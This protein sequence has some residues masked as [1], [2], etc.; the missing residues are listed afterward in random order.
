MD[1]NELLSLKHTL[2]FDENGKFRILLMSDLHAGKNFNPQLTQA[3]E[4]TV[5]HTKP[6]LV[7]INGDTS[8]CRDDVHCE[9]CEELRNL[10]KEITRPMESRKIP[11]AHTFGNHDDNYGLPIDIQQKVYEEFEY[12]IS[13]SGDEDISGTGNYVLP[14]L[15]N[16]SDKIRFNVWGFDSHSNIP[17]FAN[18][19]GLPENTRFKMRTPTYIGNDY[20]SIHPDQIHWYYSASKALEKYNGEKIPAIAFMHIAI[21]EFMVIVRNREHCGYKGNQREDLGCGD[22]NFG[23]FGACL[24]RGDVKGIFAGHDHVNDFT[25][26]YMG[27]M[28]GYDGGL[29]YDGYQ[30]DDIR[31]A[32]LFE[33]DENDAANFETRMIY[34]RDI[35]G[36]KGDRRI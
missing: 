25:G 12:C 20:D 14:V 34:T 35:M 13:K 21:P 9:T 19:L 1:I 6:N 29:T 4:A 16:S 5:A 3:I 11:W 17:K 36:E 10:L 23:F 7:L 18:Q 15:S 26:R 2:R 22:I 28:L 32:R 30:D 8:G 33:I 31:G 24:E 27:I